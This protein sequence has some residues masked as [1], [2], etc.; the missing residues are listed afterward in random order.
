MFL[1]FPLQNAHSIAFG[2]PNHQACC[3][4]RKLLHK[5]CHS[6]RIKEFVAFYKKRMNWFGRWYAEVAELHYWKV[7]HMP[8]LALLLLF[9]CHFELG[10]LD[11]FTVTGIT[12]L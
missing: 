12:K 11:L 8:P 4:D 3:D 9:S 5:P 1:K 2:L 7:W 6:V 10:K